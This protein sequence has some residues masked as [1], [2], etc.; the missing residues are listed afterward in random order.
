MI[1]NLLNKNGKYM[2]KQNIKDLLPKNNFLAK[3]TI[4]NSGYNNYKY[5]IH[6]KNQFG[7]FIQ[8]P[9]NN[10]YFSENSIIHFNDQDKNRN[11]DNKKKKKT[12]T[13]TT[14][15]IKIKSKYSDVIYSPGNFN[16]N[17]KIENFNIFKSEFKLFVFNSIDLVD[18]NEKL[19][20]LNDKFER[21]INNP[22]NKVENIIK[23]EKEFW[24]KFKEFEYS[25]M[26]N[27]EILNRKY[28]RFIFERNFTNFVIF[29]FQE[30]I[31]NP[32][33]SEIS[34]IYS[35]NNSI[36]S[37]NA[38]N[39]K[40]KVDLHSDFIINFFIENPHIDDEYKKLLLHEKLSNILKYSN[41]EM[42]RIFKFASQKILTDREYYQCLYHP[43][44]PHDKL[45]KNV[46][47]KKLSDV[48]SNKLS[49]IKNGY[50]CLQNFSLDYRNDVDLDIIKYA[51]L[52]TSNKE[53]T[54]PYMLGKIKY[55]QMYKS[56][57]DKNEINLSYNYMNFILKKFIY[58]QRILN[59]LYQFRT[60]NKFFKYID[61]EE[62]YH[63]F[64]TKLNKFL[65]K[66]FIEASRNDEIDAY[67]GINKNLQSYLKYKNFFNGISHL[68]D[69]NIGNIAI[70][71]KNIKNIKKETT[72]ENSDIIE[73]EYMD[74]LKQTEIDILFN[75]KSKNKKT[76]LLKLTSS[77]KKQNKISKEENDKPFSDDQNPGKNDLE[78]ITD[79]NFNED[80]MSEIHQKK[81]ATNVPQSL[82]YNAFEGYQ[83]INF[84]INCIL[85]NIFNL[86]PL[87]FLENIVEALKNRLIANSL[88]GNDLN[89]IFKIMAFGNLNKELLENMQNKIP[90]YSKNIT[91]NKKQLNYLYSHNFDIS[92][93]ANC[94]IEYL[95]SVENQLTCMMPNVEN[96]CFMT[97]NEKD[98]KSA[99]YTLKN[100]FRKTKA[101]NEINKKN[102]YTNLNM[103]SRRNIAEIINNLFYMRLI[104]MK[105]GNLHESLFK[106][107]IEKIVL[108]IK[109]KKSIELFDN[110]YLENLIFNTKEFK[111]KFN[112]EFLENENLCNCENYYE[113]LPEEWFYDLALISKNQEERDKLLLILLS[114]N[115]ISNEESKDSKDKLSNYFYKKEK[116]IFYE[117]IRFFDNKENPFQHTNIKYQKKFI[118]FF[119]KEI[120][121]KKY[122]KYQ[123]SY[124]YEF[125]YKL[126]RILRIGLRLTVNENKYIIKFIQNEKKNLED[127]LFSDF[128]NQ[129]ILNSGFFIIDF[130]IKQFSDEKVSGEI[131]KNEIT[132]I[133]N[134]SNLNN[135]L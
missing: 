52:E 72:K 91:Q 122:K 59:F 112:K 62:F 14:N 6:L 81:K 22:D 25:K 73:K 42:F 13:E 101:T 134:S 61:D 37:N 3:Y 70:E 27:K 7:N 29:L 129:L 67:T 35:Y 43:F 36:I 79:E 51:K 104:D 132:S 135:K 107:I 126:S 85:E 89:L 78:K 39:Y 117:L 93:F 84:E 94:Y 118:S 2:T 53:Y 77:I 56:L 113:E 71:K 41:I 76:K 65:T 92:I 87:L 130:D 68:H 23:I 58:K 116:G 60:Y 95:K 119:E 38:F 109:S 127:N 128:Y 66:N 50:E 105:E 123:I 1:K 8:N 121:D 34:K 48:I 12:P 124:D 125:D 115:K 86:K 47:I 24:K 97:E 99:D 103:Y 9:Y 46:L 26:E 45:Q 98:K 133:L 17:K 90:N 106:S 33:L 31:N 54:F 40:N 111:E 11:K 30:G 44:N 28:N 55:I 110:E 131:I 83:Y 19:K 102:S 21:I 82:Q 80:I 10:K 88:E 15:Q 5:D 49:F 63:F 16:E 20:S 57:Y 120:K 96:A 64:L 75:K 69:Y 4:N 18:L 108:L 114:F 32:L 100:Y 74:N